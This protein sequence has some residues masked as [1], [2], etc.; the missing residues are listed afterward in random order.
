MNE[1]IDIWLRIAWRRTFKKRSIYKNVIAPRRSLPFLLLISTLALHPLIIIIILPQTSF[2]MSLK[3]VLLFAGAALGHSLLGRAEGGRDFGCA[4][5]EPTEE[6]L[7]IAAQFAIEEAAALE[8]G[9]TAQA[10]IAVD[11][12][13]HAVAATSGGLTTVRDT[14]LP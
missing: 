3:S 6:D 4:T 9:F 8:S 5:P 1:A 12:W 7:A 13:L 14:H 11:V 10:A 2:I